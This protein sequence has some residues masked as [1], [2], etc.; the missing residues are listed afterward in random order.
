MDGSP[1]QQRVCQLG[2]IAACRDW[3]VDEVNVRIR[4]IA[5]ER[6]PGRLSIGTLT[7]KN[8][9]ARSFTRMNNVQTDYR[10]AL[11]AR[12]HRSP[13]KRGELAAVDRSQMWGDG[14][15]FPTKSCG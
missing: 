7:P 15:I 2:I 13:K 6:R 11:P 9:H 10:A 14:H 4:R 3:S 5:D 1:G 8:Q 12:E